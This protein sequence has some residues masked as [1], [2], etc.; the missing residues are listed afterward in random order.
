[1]CICL[2]FCKCVCVCGGGDNVI[3]MREK[4]ARLSLNYSRYLFLSTAL[5]YVIMIKHKCP[6]I[7]RCYQLH[8]IKITKIK[9]DAPFLE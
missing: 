1:M 7:R 5:N 3:F 4:K 2:C 8:S 6:L 9:C